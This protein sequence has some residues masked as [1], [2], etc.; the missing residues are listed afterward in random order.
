MA[1][2][3]DAV[4]RLCRREGIKLFLK[5]TKCFSDMAQ[6]K[7]VILLP[8]NTGRIVR[9]EFLATASN[10]VKSRKP[11]ACISRRR[12]KF[13]NYFEKAAHT[14]GV[15]GEIL[16]QQLERRVDNVVFR[17]G[18][19]PVAAPGAPISAARACGRQR[20]QGEHP[21]VRSGCGAGNHHSGRQP[22]TDDPGAGEGLRQSP[23]RRPRGWTS[24]AMLTKAA[25]CLAEREEIQLPVNEQLIVELYSK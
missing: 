22:Q 16:L 20:T 7:S 21:F 25:S 23:H 18:F 2:Y 5:G 12:A 17:L 4:C 19:A 3:T 24:I 15:T 8:D 6:S 11:S 1:R 14:K 13:R 9:P 10:C